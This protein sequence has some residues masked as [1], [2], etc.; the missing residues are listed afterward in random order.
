MS[1]FA[2][3]SLLIVL[4]ALFSFVNYR[5]IGLPTTIG[6]TL[7]ALVMSLLLIAAS[8]LGVPVRG[9]AAALIQRLNFGE[10]VLNQMLAFLL[11]A[12]A[13]NVDLD[14]LLGQKLSVALLA[15]V[16]VL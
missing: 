11:F 5:F 1:V 9:V 6:V 2:L 8:E 16:G 12:G 14:E 4:G 13:L 7:M 15:T 3:L 10:V